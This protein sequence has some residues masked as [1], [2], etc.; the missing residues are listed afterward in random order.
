M[1]IVDQ[2]EDKSMSDRIW[3][4]IEWIKDTYPDEFEQSIRVVTVEERANP[5]LYYYP[6]DEYDFIY[7]GLHPQYI[8]AFI[9]DIKVKPNGRIYGYSH[10]S[11]FYDAIAVTTLDILLR[12]DGPAHGIIQKRIYRREE[13]WKC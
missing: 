8:K 6:D 9:A 12:R 3:R 11:K 13:E 4:M 7:A 10:I 5:A 1:V 2:I